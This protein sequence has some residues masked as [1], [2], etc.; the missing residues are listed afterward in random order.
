MR[1]D[2]IKDVEVVVPESG[3]AVMVNAPVDGLCAW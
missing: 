3:A 2:A 1:L